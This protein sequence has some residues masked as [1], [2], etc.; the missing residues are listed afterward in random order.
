M[1][2][3]NCPCIALAWIKLSFKYEFHLTS[4]DEILRFS[5]KIPFFASLAKIVKNIFQ[6]TSAARRRTFFRKKYYLLNMFKFDHEPISSHNDISFILKWSAVGRV[7]WLPTYPSNIKTLEYI[8]YFRLQYELGLPIW[9]GRKIEK[10]P[11][12]SYFRR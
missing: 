2:L 4:L 3:S 12:I 5:R 8:L 11:L 10:L 7:P 1:L 6:W 9:F